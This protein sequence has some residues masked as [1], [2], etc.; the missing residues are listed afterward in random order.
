MSGGEFLLE[1]LCEE[2]P[3]KALPGIREQLV[4]LFGKE[5]VEAAFSGCGVRALSTVR[6]LVV[7]VTGLPE[8]Q[9]D[10]EEEVFGPSVRAAF[11]DDGS[12]TPAA[13]GF[14]KG[15][16]VSVDGLRV[17]PGPKGD[18]VAA[19][20]RIEGRPS[21]E[22]L[23]E[24][25]ARVLHSLRFPKTMR[26][27]R[28]DFSFVRP[29]HN[30]LALF[31]LGVLDTVVQFE[32]FGL[33]SGSTSFGHRIFHPEPVDL[34]GKKGFG[35]Y[36]NWLKAVAVMVDP[37]ERRNWL[38][39][40]MDELAS[41]V[42]CSARQDQALLDEIV[43]L[44][45]CPRFA[46]G[47]FDER[48]LQL[49]EVV[50]VTT[51]RHHQKCFVLE[52]AGKV[53]PFFLAVCDWQGEPT[54]EIV[55]G[56]EWVVRA[57][58]ADAAFFFAQDRRQPLAAR[59]AALERV[60]FHQKLGS[61]AA[62]ADLVG[63]LAARLAAEAELGLEA[64]LVRHACALLKL[65]LT[66]A[67][68]GEFP[69]LQG[70]MG[71]IYAQSEGEPEAVCDAIADQYQPAG[72]EG[73]LPR[74]PLAAIV[75]VADRLDTLAALFSIGE[76][77]SGSKDPFAL[78]RAALAVVRICAEAPLALDLRDAA[79]HALALREHGKAKGGEG[80]A[81]LCEFVQE[82]LR[83]YLTATAGVSAAAADAVIAARWGVV[84]DDLARARAVEAVRNEDVFAALAEAFKRVRNM[85]A[86]GGV[87]A[88][89]PKRLREPAEKELARQLDKVEKDVLKTES[90]TDHLASLRALATLAAP[91]D[92]FFTDVLVLCDDVELRDARLALLARVEK[93]FLRLADVSKLSA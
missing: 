91:L 70:V 55:H 48:F 11:S 78:R 41:Q 31:G 54:E 64:D 62:K 71:G 36:R 51:L 79:R 17:V 38:R 14:A 59:R 29:V 20:R 81:R 2:I 84:P 72:L 65:D 58:L 21:A 42:G 68:V 74:G 23:G 66:T 39:A 34:L 32:L 57:R 53:A 80:L 5:L 93:L 89:S 52:R 24:I 6:R 1:V 83:Y 44:V 86:K 13:L 75:G 69:E 92:G 76:V 10:R 49:P 85:V 26:W 82:R 33:Q 63:E 87:G 90:R 15:Q 3:A 56:N 28:G 27:G 30:V 50:V 8:R 25:A 47:E 43:E 67:M 16:G 40:R 45:E 19:T 46:R 60:V 12:P 61:F 18:V 88:A 9:P 37:E 4:E 77:P 7:S 73:P 35:D 22:V